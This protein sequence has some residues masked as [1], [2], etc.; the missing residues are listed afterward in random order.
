MSK[1]KTN[2]EIYKYIEKI[3]EGNKYS[4]TKL[5]T[6]LINLYCLSEPFK[7]KSRINLESF[8]SIITNS[9]RIYDRNFDEDWRSIEFPPYDS[10]IGYD[11]WQNEILEQTVD[12]REMDEAGMLQSKDK[13]FGITSPRGNDWYNFD[14]VDYLECAVAGFFGYVQDEGEALIIN[15]SGAPEIVNAE[16]FPQNVREIRLVTW[17]DYR[18]FLICGRS[19]E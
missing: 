7:N 17:D 3:N 1:I 8:L 18:S 14:P 19:Y 16:E 15:D 12:F 9:F 2:R 13:Y 6:Y 10:R 5:D 4:N 11:G